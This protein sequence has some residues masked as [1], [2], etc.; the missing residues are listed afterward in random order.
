MKAIV[1]DPSLVA[2]CGLYC[3]ACKRYLKDKCPGC[4]E[5]QK[6]TW[7]KL[8]SCCME[9][10]YASCADCK[11][12][13]DPMACRK[14]NNFMSKLFGFIFRSDRN[15]CIRKIREVGVQGYADEMSR[16]G[17]PSLKRQ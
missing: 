10:G 5:N 8:R 7:C 15:A 3:G 2:Y 9:N 12:F 16:L 11:E 6:A 4:R 1:S 13:E 14:F 17:L